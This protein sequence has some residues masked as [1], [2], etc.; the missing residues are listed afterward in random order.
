MTTKAIEVTIPEATTELT[1]VTIIDPATIELDPMTEQE[2][3]D[4]AVSGLRELIEAKYHF[5][6]RYSDMM[7]ERLPAAIKRDQ[8]ARL[9][10]LAAIKVLQGLTWW[11]AE[12]C[13]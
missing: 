3:I 13:K 12:Q 1:Q 8:A 2:A 10:Y 4:T 7:G 11:E 9:R 6:N 5:C